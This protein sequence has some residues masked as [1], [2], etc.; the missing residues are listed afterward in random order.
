MIE[1]PN[2]VPAERIIA[3]F[4][5]DASAWNQ[6]RIRYTCS[7]CGGSGD[8]GRTQNPAVHEDLRQHLKRQHRMKATSVLRSETLMDHRGAISAIKFLP[9][10]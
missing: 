9:W 4:Y 7:L 1:I 3:A 10:G 5:V 6:G 2:A 8:A